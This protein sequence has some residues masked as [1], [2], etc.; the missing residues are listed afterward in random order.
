MKGKTLY[1]SSYIRAYIERLFFAYI[2]RPISS[3]ENG[4]HIYKQL[5]TVKYS[6]SYMV[7]LTDR[8]IRKR[9]E[10]K[11][12]SRWKSLIFLL[13]QL[14][15]ERIYNTMTERKFCTE[16]RKKNF[17]LKTENL[18]MCKILKKN[19]QKRNFLLKRRKRKFCRNFSEVA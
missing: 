11:R 18:F 15:T 5:K 19:Y 10:S 1:I 12:I 3:L 2:Q 14:V 8:P 7:R 6:P 9:R 16:N 4:S 17:I 13:F